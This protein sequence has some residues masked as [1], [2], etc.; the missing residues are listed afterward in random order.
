MPTTTLEVSLKRGKKPIKW[1]KLTEH[2][3][4]FVGKNE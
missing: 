1:L 3:L 4:T 2:S